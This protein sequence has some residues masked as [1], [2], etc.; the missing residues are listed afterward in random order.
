MCM[1]HGRRPC[2]DPGR[3]FR[4]A[5]VR[6]YPAITI[7][8]GLEVGLIVFVTN[9]CPFPAFQL[10][11]LRATVSKDWWSTLVQAERERRIS[12]WLTRWL[13]S[14]RTPPIVTTAKQYT[15]Y[16]HASF[17]PPRQLSFDTD[18]MWANAGNGD[19]HPLRGAAVY[20][21]DPSRAPEAVLAF[22]RYWTYHRQEL[23]RLV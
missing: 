13:A 18:A 12:Q 22:A 6:R 8:L 7:A 5:C 23:H 16:K 17:S 4:N 10:K 19:R 2:H 20:V 1:F 21:Y 11:W 9:A 14:H 15:A 3:F